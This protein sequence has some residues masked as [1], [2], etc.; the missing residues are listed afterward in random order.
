MDHLQRLVGTYEA[1]WHRPTLCH[2]QHFYL[3]GLSP[4]QLVQQVLQLGDGD[5][6][7]ADHCRQ[8]L[9]S[10]ARCRFLLGALA[11]Q[12]TDRPLFH[13]WTGLQP[14]GAV[15]SGQ[16]LK[17]APRF[18]AEPRVLQ[19]DRR[20]A[21]QHQQQVLVVFGK[22]AA[23][24]LVVHRQYADRTPLERHRH[25]QDGIDQ[26]AGDHLQGLLLP[27]ETFGFAAL[28]HL[29]GQTVVNLDS[30]PARILVAQPFLRP[31]VQIL[32]L[33]IQQ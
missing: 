11:Q 7:G 29:S 15:Q 25:V 17:L 10:E 20:I 12:D 4:C 27:S 6:A 33:I 8:E 26:V 14:S 30:E 32:C 21:G 13:G 28:E 16:R 31:Q 9:G 2:G 24:G 22:G 19:R 18:F 23:G 1:G 3:P 5:Q